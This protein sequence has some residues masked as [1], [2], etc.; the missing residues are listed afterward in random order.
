MPQA[1]CRRLLR[2][3]VIA[4][5]EVCRRPGHR[6]ARIAVL[7][8]E[9]GR[10]AAEPL[11]VHA[12]LLA[13]EPIPLF[14]FSEAW[15]KFGEPIASALADD[16]LDEVV[17]ALRNF[18]LVERETVPDERNP[19]ITMETIRLHRL[20]REVAAAREGEARED[21]LRTLIEE[22]AAVYPREV[23]DDPKSWPRARTSRIGPDA[24]PV[25]LG[26]QN[27]HGAELACHRATNKI[28]GAGRQVPRDFWLIV[29]IEKWKV[30][31]GVVVQS[32]LFEAKS[33]NLVSK[34]Q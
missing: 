19:V 28:R 18:A 29:T 15:E 32:C 25:E 3:V 12:A 1:G 8:R 5:E 2:P 14:L 24:P 6:P 13:P 30:A 33:Y 7:L 27:A 16:G 22:M 9:F 10:P 17:A 26:N 21:M 20:V 31:V 4:P 34:N 11:I 23:F